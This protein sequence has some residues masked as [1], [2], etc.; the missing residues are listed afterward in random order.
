MKARFA[1]VVLALGVLSQTKALGDDNHILGSN[2]R[3]SAAMPRAV[4]PEQQCTVSYRLDWKG[5]NDISGTVARMQNC[6]SSTAFHKGLPEYL[7]KHPMFA[8]FRKDGGAIGVFPDDRFPPAVF[9]FYFRQSCEQKEA[10][11]QA[12]LDVCREEGHTLPSMTLIPDAIPLDYAISGAFLMN[13]CKALAYAPSS[14]MDGTTPDYKIRDWVH[15]EQMLVCAGAIETAKELMFQHHE[16]CMG[17]VSLAE[18]ADVV[19]K[20]IVSHRHADSYPSL[21][22]AALQKKWP[23]KPS[24][25][26]R[27]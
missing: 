3:P 23:C 7:S 9:H 6:Q 11:A 18:A 12:Y 27:K 22:F 10:M 20:Y 26:A 25:T 5:I 24:P 17:D 19:A 4:A 14:F 15:Q 2:D 13:G 16:A 21:V 8:L 1:F